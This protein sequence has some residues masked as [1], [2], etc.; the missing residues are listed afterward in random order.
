MIGMVRTAL[1]GALMVMLAG[2]AAPQ[3]QVVYVP[4]PQAPQQSTP[5]PATPAPAGL[6]E[7]ERE[8]QRAWRRFCIDTASEVDQYV[9]ARDEGFD[10]TVVRDWA[11]EQEAQSIETLRLN[12][13]TSAERDEVDTIAELTLMMTQR[14]VQQVYQRPFGDVEQERRFWIE[15][16][17]ELID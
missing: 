6:S 1:T 11:L 8:E 14:L 10:F 15:N 5:V 7:Q 12:A 16:C 2:C 9:Y 4:Y 3:P 17:M 13:R